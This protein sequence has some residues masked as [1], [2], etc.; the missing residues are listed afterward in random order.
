[1]KPRIRSCETC[2]HWQRR[3]DFASLGQFNHVKSGVRLTV[4]PRRLGSKRQGNYIRYGPFGP[5]Y[6]SRNRATLGLQVHGLSTQPK[7]ESC[8]Y[9]IFSL[10]S[11]LTPW[12]A[13]A[14][15]T[16]Y[17][18]EQCNHYKNPP[19]SAPYNSK[20]LQI[21]RNLLPAVFMRITTSSRQAQYLLLNH[22]GTTG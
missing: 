15:A 1:M 6:D 4:A 22:N 3:L 12:Q 17:Q 18:C 13:H 16:S 14:L 19:P 7:R 20:L 2:S 8:A 21:Y 11:L 5:K 10:T 9:H